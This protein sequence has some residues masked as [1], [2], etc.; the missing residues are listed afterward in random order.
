MTFK[1]LFLTIFFL[2]ALTSPALSRE[3]ITTDI[4][5]IYK[6]EIPYK[7][8]KILNHYCDLNIQNP[9]D[10]KEIERLAKI[11]IKSHPH[12]HTKESALE[13]TLDY[14]KIFKEKFVVYE[15]REYKKEYEISVFI[16]DHE[17]FYFTI[18]DN[19]IYDIYWGAMTDFIGVEHLFTKDYQ[20][21]WI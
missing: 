9:K 10:K 4:S 5:K 15:I 3:I 12:N 19:K 17:R 20:Q 8:R 13:E 14:I 18:R 2:H 7:L 21:Y 6:T 16:G 11:I 1:T